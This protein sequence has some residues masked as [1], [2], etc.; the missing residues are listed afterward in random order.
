M[1]KGIDQFKKHFRPYHENY[2]LIGG[3]A[4]F[5]AFEYAGLHFRSTKD[6]D[7]VICLEMQ[8]AKFNK[9]IWEF[10]NEGQYQNQQQSTGKKQFYR[11]F[12]PKADNFPQMVEFFSRKPD[13]ITLF[14]NSKLTPIPVDEEILSLSAILLDDEYYPLIL[15]GKHLID[16]ISA[17]SPPYLIPLKARA[18][19]N[20][21]KMRNK[22]DEKDIRKHR[23]DIIRLYPLLSVNSRIDLPE[24]IKHDFQRFLEELKAQ[25]PEL[26]ALGL[27]NTTI[28]EIISNLSQ[29]YDL[30]FS[31]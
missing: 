15:K 5:L 26:K 22:V 25:P 31:K 20:L 28:H 17:L 13:S 2:V 4:C 12:S 24:T 6:L 10:I 30:P 21:S 19:L 16:G 29:I 3:T 23:N 18:W 11:F 27:K 7:I 9:A 14:K 8:D 1:V